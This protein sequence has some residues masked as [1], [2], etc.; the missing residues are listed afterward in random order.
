MEESNI[1]IDDGFVMKSI[2]NKKSHTENI[3]N[4]PW[5]LST[6]VL[7]IL[8][9]FF[10][11]Q[12]FG[13]LNGTFTGNVVSQDLIEENVNLIVENSPGVSSFEISNI[14]IVE[15]VYLISVFIDGTSYSFSSTLDGEFLGMPDGYWIRVSEFKA[16]LDSQVNQEPEIFQSVDGEFMNFPE[17]VIE[18]TI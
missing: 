9:L 16:Y 18:E 7:G 11:L 2:S 10:V 15:N 17:E 12:S 8:T 5:I 4:N 13:F 1:K 6:F 14:E 3:R